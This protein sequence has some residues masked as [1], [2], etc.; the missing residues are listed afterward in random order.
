MSSHLIGKARRIASSTGL[1]ASTHRNGG[2]RVLQEHE[3]V[4][5][6][7]T[8]SAGWSRGHVCGSARALERSL[9]QTLEV[10]AGSEH[11]STSPWVELGSPR[12][13]SS[14]APPQTKSLLA[15]ASVQF[16]VPPTTVSTFADIRLGVSSISVS[17]FTIEHSPSRGRGT[18]VMRSLLP[19]SWSA[20]LAEVTHTRDASEGLD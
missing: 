18:R 9:A 15:P 3:R 17:W 13:R 12:P 4:C 7:S 11:V 8:A 20:D 14:P 6:M 19:S 5:S 2:N 1:R 16:G 10:E